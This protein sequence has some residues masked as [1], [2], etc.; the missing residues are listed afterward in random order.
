MS[1]S[2]PAQVQNEELVHER[3]ARIIAAAIVL[4]IAGM[5]IDGASI[6]LVLVPLLIPAVRVGFAAWPG[7]SLFHSW[8]GD[9]ASGDDPSRVRFLG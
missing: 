7:Y 8:L 4:L 2:I 6:Y 1:R 9:L 5:F 3:R